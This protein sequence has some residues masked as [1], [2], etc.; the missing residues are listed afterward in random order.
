MNKFRLLLN[1]YIYFFSTQLPVLQELIHRLLKTAFKFVFNSFRN[2]HKNIQRGNNCLYVSK[3]LKN[4]CTSHLKILIIV[5]LSIP[6]C[7]K[8]HQD[9]KLMIKKAKVRYI[10]TLF[11]GIDYRSDCF[12]HGQLV[13]RMRKLVYIITIWY[14]KNQECCLLWNS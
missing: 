7:H 2:Y 13:S 6:K 14:T 10:M 5:L 9:K 11:A 12:S 8:L 4:Y 1:C 3:N